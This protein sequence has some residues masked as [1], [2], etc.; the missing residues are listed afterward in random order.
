[1]EDI[2]HLP[3]AHSLQRGNSDNF[4]LSIKSFPI[5]MVL[6]GDQCF[7]NLV[8]SRQQTRGLSV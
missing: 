4:L 3:S 7:L 1:M 5:P 6:L 8:A 2:A